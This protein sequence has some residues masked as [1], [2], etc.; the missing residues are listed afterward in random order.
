MLERWQME[1]SMQKQHPKQN[2][3]KLQKQHPKQKQI[4]LQNLVNQRRLKQRPNR[5]KHRK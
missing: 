2:Q 5:L 4:K 1:V 3:I